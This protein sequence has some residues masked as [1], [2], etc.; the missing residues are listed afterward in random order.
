MTAVSDVGR[1]IQQLHQTA[2]HLR[3]ALERL[4]FEK[5]DAVQKA[6]ADNAGEIEQL[7]QVAQA[8]RTQLERMR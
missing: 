2:Q 1:E 6:V 5:N 4:Q 8:L 7:K 3:D